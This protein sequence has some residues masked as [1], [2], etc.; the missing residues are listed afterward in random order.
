MR[1]RTF[2]QPLSHGRKFTKEES[3]DN[4][5]YLIKQ[6]APVAEQIGTH[7][8]IHPQLGGVPRCIFGNLHGYVKALEFGNRPNIGVCLCCG[9]WMG[10]GKYIGKD[11]FEAAWAFAKMGE[12]WK[13]IFQCDSAEPLLCRRMSTWIHGHEKLMPALGDIDFRG[14]LCRSRTPHAGRRSVPDGYTVSDIARLSMIWRATNA[15]KDNPS[16]PEP[17]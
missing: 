9:T 15:A 3:S 4:Y 8:G 6:V 11:V 17:S 5:T 13:T 14:Y 12:L 2:E 1:G 10:G 7:I 16:C